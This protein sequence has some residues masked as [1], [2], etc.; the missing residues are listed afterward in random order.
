MKGT[1]KRL[2][3]VAAALCM[4]MSLMAV[5]AFAADGDEDKNNYIV[6]FYPG[7]HGTFA[8]SYTCLLYTSSSPLVQD[9]MQ[10]KSSWM[11]TLSLRNFRAL[12]WV[13]T[14]AITVSYTHLPSVA[15]WLT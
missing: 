12:T 4:A 9:M 11:R 3:A 15:P 1:I 8:E 7:E 2:C 6:V 5:P 14:R 13:A 10:T